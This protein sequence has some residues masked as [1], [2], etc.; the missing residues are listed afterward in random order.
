MTGHD[1]A[2]RVAAATER[3]ADVST[4]AATMAWS[5]VRGAELHAHLLRAGATEGGD[6]E[7]VAVPAAMDSELANPLADAGYLERF[8]L[9]DLLPMLMQTLVELDPAN[10]VMS[11]G[12]D[13]RTMPHMCTIAVGAA[14]LPTSLLRACSLTLPLLWAPWLIPPPGGGGGIN[15][16]LPPLSL[17]RPWNRRVHVCVICLSSFDCPVPCRG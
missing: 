16:L 12:V 17:V 6:G 15:L 9:V 14:R 4:A 8:F 3:G 1:G 7:A 11:D 2:T 10:V 13:P 5:T